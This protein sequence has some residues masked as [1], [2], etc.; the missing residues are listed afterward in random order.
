MTPT[1]YSDITARVLDG[2]ALR[3][4]SLYWPR[5][6]PPLLMERARLIASAIPSGTIA[7]GVTAGWV[8][9]GM[10]IPTP[11]SLIA[12][13]SPSPSPLIRHEWR[14]RGVKAHDTHITRMGPLTLLTPHATANDLWTCEADN[15]VASAQLFWL[16]S[17]PPNNNQEQTRRRQ[18]LVGQWR[19]DY[20]WA[21]RY[22]S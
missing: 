11:L 4:G 21:T 1:D 16:D 19:A 6:E 3:I 9:T 8:W 13:S 10:G 2:E 7:A 15:E 17:A 5:P 12:A 22:T 18:G 14:I 20:P